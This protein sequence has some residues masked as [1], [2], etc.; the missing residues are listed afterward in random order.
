MTTD[1]DRIGFW[2]RAASTTGRLGSPYGVAGAGRFADHLERQPGG[3]AAQERL[4]GPDL[5]P[6]GGGRPDRQLDRVRPQVEPQRVVR[7]A[8][9]QPQVGGGVA[10]VAQLDHVPAPPASGGG[11][12]DDLGLQPG[13]LAELDVALRRRADVRGLGRAGEHPEGEGPAL[14]LGA[15]RRGE[16]D[17]RGRLL[18]GED[19]HGGRHHLGPG[20]RLGPEHGEVEALDDRAGARHGDRDLGLPTRLDGHPRGVQ[21]EHRVGHGDQDRRAGP[22]L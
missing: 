4:A 14:R 1:R 12:R 20:R 5:Q 18:A 17:D 10:P 21:A 8:R 7:V 2:F 13:D 6:D 19:V 11:D 3:G 22:R 16:H 15:A 9:H